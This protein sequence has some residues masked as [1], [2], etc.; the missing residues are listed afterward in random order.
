MKGVEKLSILTK[1]YAG[2]TTLR[3]GDKSFAFATF[4]YLDDIPLILGHA[5]LDALHAVQNL[6]INQEIPFLV[7]F[8]CE[9]H[10]VML[11]NLFGHVCITDSAEWSDAKWKN[12]I[13]ASYD[14]FGPDV[15]IREAVVYM[16]Y[17]LANDIQNNLDDWVQ[18]DASLP[19][20]DEEARLYAQEVANRTQM[21]KSLTVLLR[22]DAETTEEKLKSCFAADYFSLI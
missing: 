6:D 18:W 5:L 21:L 10:D 20:P 14:V 19:D 2:W 22:A 3:I 1:P 17:G 7:S 13:Y 9:G 15:D 8:D 16:A 4:S 12:G 11:S